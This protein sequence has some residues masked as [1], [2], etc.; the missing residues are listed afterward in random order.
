MRVLILYTRTALLTPHSDS[1]ALSFL[2]QSGKYAYHLIWCN[3]PEDLLLDHSAFIISEWTAI[4]FRILVFYDKVNFV[5]QYNSTNPES[6]YPDSLGPSGKHFSYCK[7]AA[8][9]YGC[10]FPPVC[11]TYKVLRINV[12]FV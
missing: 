5:V 4:K 12:V 2:S 7:C 11:Q 8:Y 3:D 6:A 9:F 1:S 10:T